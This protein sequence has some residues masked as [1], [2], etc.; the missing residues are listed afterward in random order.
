LIFLVV[1]QFWATLFGQSI[2]DVGVYRVLGAAILAFG[3]S[4]WWAYRE[5]LWERV[6]LLTEMEMVWTILGALVTVYALLFEN[7]IVAGWIMA[8]TLV[9]FA[10]VFAYFYVRE[11]ASTAQP[12]TR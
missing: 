9:L 12:L 3:A 7:M 6:K 8:I 11:G 1:P 4:S 10:V 5:N 2:V